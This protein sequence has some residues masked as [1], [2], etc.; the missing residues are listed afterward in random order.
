[1]V[2]E[3]NQ[4]LMVQRFHTWRMSIHYPVTSQPCQRRWPSDWT[5][6]SHVMTNQLR[7]AEIRVMQLIT[8]SVLELLCAA[9]AESSQSLAKHILFSSRTFSCS[10]PLF[11]YD[12]LHV[13]S[14]LNLMKN[15]F[16]DKASVTLSLLVVYIDFHQR[17]DHA[18]PLTCRSACVYLGRHVHA[19]GGD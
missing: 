2:R 1:M 11:H 3:F 8:L 17:C 6:R 15:Q 4:D 5:G 7:A 13:D 14:L 9:L 18:L 12:H 10:T 16:R 19:L